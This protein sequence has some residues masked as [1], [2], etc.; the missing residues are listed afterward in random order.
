MSGTNGRACGD[1][2]VADEHRG[3]PPEHVQD[4]LENDPDNPLFA[5]IDADVRGTDNPTFNNLSHGLARIL[6]PLPDNMDVIDF[7]GN[8]VTPPD[9]IVE[10]WRA[11]PSIINTSF[12]GPYL[13]DGR[14]DTLEAQ[15]L[16]AIEH[17]SESSHA[18][19]N[20]LLKRIADFERTQFSSDRA[21]FVHEQLEAGIPA[22]DIP[23]PEDD[24]AFLA[25]L[26]PE[27]LHGKEVYD[28][29]CMGCHGGARDDIIVD[30][31]IHDALCF[32]PRPDGN[33][34]RDFTDL[35]DNGVFDI[36]LEG[37]TLVF[38]APEEGCGEFPF[39]GITAATVLGQIGLA[40]EPIPYNITANFPAYRFRF[41]RD[42]A[43]TEHWTDL[44]PLPL[45]NE[46]GLPAVDERGVP[47]AGPSGGPIP[48]TTDP[49]RALITGNPSDFEG[50]DVPQLRGIANT[51]PYFHD[52]NVLTLEEV[53]ELYSRAILPA[54]PGGPFPPIHVTPQ[55]S[56]FP[57][58]SLSPAEKADLVAFLEVF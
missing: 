3:L 33:L 39:I 34:N 46:Q 48:F 51:A 44:P 56:F 19:G 17:H 29:A 15:A 28:F 24:P 38:E 10:V 9:R 45:F 41:Y 22:A 5:D 54:I 1:C 37:L 35:N 57:G 30:R 18:T 7:A 52:N 55:P 11:V 36:A 2:H 43:R 58:E 23:I 40:F 42:N 47:I 14:A 49:G 16:G 4:L 8:V 50:F 53:V 26:T 25:T 31:Q 20:G 12:T 21:R 27:Q 13:Y 6:I 32:A